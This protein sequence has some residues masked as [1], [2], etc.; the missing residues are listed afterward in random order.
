MTISEFKEKFFTLVEESERIVIT[1]HM[2]PDDDSIGSV[3][4]MLAVLK[5]RYP[6]KD[7]RIMYSNSPLDRWR[8]L[9]NF[10]KIEWKDDIANH[11][12]EEDLIVM[13]DA[14]RHYLCTKLPEQ[15][16]ALP[17]RVAIDHHVSQAD[18][19]ELI[20][21]DSQYSSNVELLYRIF[22]E[23]KDLSKYVAEYLLLGVLG[24]TGNFRHVKPGQEDVFDLAK[25]L[26]PTVGVS[27]DEFKSRFGGIPR[28]IIPLMQELTKNITY[29]TVEGWPQ[30]QYSY[31]NRASI[32]SFTEDEIS[33]ASHL[34]IGQYLTQVEGC[35]WGFV[36]TPRHDGTC[37]ISGRSLPKS[38]NIRDMFE[39]L[40]IGGG[41]DRASGGKFNESDPQKCVAKVLEWMHSNKPTLG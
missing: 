1:S 14:S 18:E 4:I 30:V 34:Y 3:L 16:S 40:G 31:I 26:L 7:I 33:A 21:Q 27:I 35:P 5:E 23:D 8:S 36:I 13:L 19:F 28:K 32:K 41:H 29:E 37:R 6:T 24:D 9:D 17:H 15:L 38:V 39:R 20:F 12:T 2:S 10:E 25:K 22:L 11:V